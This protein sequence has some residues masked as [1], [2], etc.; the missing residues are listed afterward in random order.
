MLEAHD[1]KQ[2][3]DL[4]EEKVRPIVKAEIQASEDRI[5]V[6]VGEMIEQNVTPVL[7]KMDGRIDKMDGRIDNMDSRM[8][9]MDGKLDDMRKT[10]ANLPDKTYLDAKLADREGN[11]VVRQKKQNEKVNLVID[12]LGKKKVFEEREMQ[13]LN[14][15]HV[16]PSP[17][18]VA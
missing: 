16:F 10:I 2:L 18:M 12:F 11:A 7:D 6:A 13:Q 8:D 17:P 1:I 9:K 5:I 14:A 3:G 4:I 15:M